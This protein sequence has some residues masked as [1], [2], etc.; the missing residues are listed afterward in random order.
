[1]LASELIKELQECIGRCGD[2]EIAIGVDN[3]DS[4]LFTNIAAVDEFSD[5]PNVIQ[6][7]YLGF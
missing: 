4:P 1:M 5:N 7:L 2:K 3:G 6:I